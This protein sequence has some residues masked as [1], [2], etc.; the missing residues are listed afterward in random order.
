MFTPFYNSEQIEGF[1]K[2][3]NSQ[4]GQSKENPEQYK[5]QNFD[6]IKICKK[7]KEL[8]ISNSV[9]DAAHRKIHNFI[10]ITRFQYIDDNETQ[11]NSPNLSDLDSS[12]YCRKYKLEIRSENFS[13]PE[14]AD[15]QILS[16]NDEEKIIRKPGFDLGDIVR[17][18]TIDGFIPTNLLINNDET[19]FVLYNKKAIIAGE[20]P[21]WKNEPE[22]KKSEVMRETKEKI[23]EARIVG[24]PYAKESNSEILKVE[25]HPLNDYYIGVLNS[26]GNFSLYN[27]ESDL[28]K[29]EQTYDIFKKKKSLEDI[30]SGINYAKT[31]TSFCFGSKINFGWSSFTVF[32]LTMTGDIYLLCPIIPYEINLE[33]LLIDILLEIIKNENPITTKFYTQKTEFLQILENAETDTNSRNLILNKEKILQLRPLLQG[34]INLYRNINTGEILAKNYYEI[35]GFNYFPYVFI[36]STDKSICDIC[37][38]F[39]DV[40]PVFAESQK[41]GLGLRDEKRAVCELTWINMAKVV[42]SPETKITFYCDLNNP[43]N[44]FAGVGTRLYEISNIWLSE[45]QKKIQI[46]KDFSKDFFK[47]LPN[48]QSTLIIKDDPKG[49]FLLG[50]QQFGDCIILL[51]SGSNGIYTRIFNIYNEMFFSSSRK[52]S[53]RPMK[54]FDKN[55]EK[56]QSKLQSIDSKLIKSIEPFSLKLESN[57]EKEYEN[58]QIL[59]ECQKQF[60]TYYA[61]SKKQA[62]KLILENNMDIIEKHQKN[63]ENS[64]GELFEKIDNLLKSREN[65]KKSLQNC[66]QTNVFFIQFYYKI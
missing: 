28:D 45:I 55:S 49:N 66:I 47:T 18:E 3:L 5:T 1:E 20:I 31:I 56:I 35:I 38:S 64:V 16:K 32:F 61:L 27:L 46:E 4:L 59:E 10:H 36:L 25:F 2:F 33:P 7:T 17:K 43:Y 65:L 40:N 37:V 60:P 21:E 12:K 41:V 34:P 14:S 19:L 48:S 23:L 9:F 58:L 42:M 52:I 22:N 6:L 24:L 15:S 44:F 8:I 13:P 51:K 30:K 53:S 50:I 57:Q 11:K 29:P 63:V 26:S 62:E 54:K 39:E